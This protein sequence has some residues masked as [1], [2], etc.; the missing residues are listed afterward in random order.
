MH[1]LHL[2]THL[3]CGWSKGRDRGKHRPLQICNIVKLLASQNLLQCG[4]QEEITVGQIRAVR[5]MTKHFNGPPVDRFLS[6]RSLIARRIVRSAT[7]E[8]VSSATLLTSDVC[9]AVRPSHIRIR[10]IPLVPLMQC[11][12]LHC[13]IAVC[14][15]QHFHSF[16]SVFSIE[17]TEF[18][19]C[20][21]FD[22]HF[23]AP[24]INK[25]AAY[26]QMTSYV[27]VTSL[28]SC[29]DLAPYCAKVW[30]RYWIRRK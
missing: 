30:R 6:R 2:L 23:D 29:Q 3:V 24:C 16:S 15:D 27:D 21:L 11:R 28:M 10:F 14:L 20:S 8:L 19:L 17:N 7:G 25:M 4:K 1:F 22:A 9:C 26:A 12:F 5:R 18:N 13:S